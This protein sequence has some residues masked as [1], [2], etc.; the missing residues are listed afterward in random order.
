MATQ[1][2]YLS[3]GMEEEGVEDH[4]GWL[5]AE[6]KQW[7]AS[8]RVLVD[9]DSKEEVDKPQEKYSVALLLQRRTYETPS[10]TTKHLR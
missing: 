10:S 8:T 7:Y 2:A 3:F 6:V 5:M 1:R 4:L 9:A